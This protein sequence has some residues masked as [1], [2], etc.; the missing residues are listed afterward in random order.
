M[1][2]PYD[3]EQV[4]IVLDT[5]TRYF[6]VMETNLP[7]MYAEKSLI[8]DHEKWKDD[9]IKPLSGPGVYQKDDPSMEII[10]PKMYSVGSLRIRKL[11][12]YLLD[13]K[14][15]N[16]VELENKIIELES[17]IERQ[18][19]VIEDQDEKINTI[20]S[21]FPE[22]KISKPK[23]YAPIDMESYMEAL[24]KRLQ[25]GEFIIKTLYEDHTTINYWFL[26][27]YGRILSKVSIIGYLKEYH[28]IIKKFVMV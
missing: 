12:Q 14:P 28:K 22:D 8:S 17:V 11:F 25:P 18:K 7:N 5:L 1:E 21:L 3:D 26:T 4:K 23:E 2:K 19:K 20:M 16:V 6:H 15:N 9:Q 27:N 13:C 10:S 24:K